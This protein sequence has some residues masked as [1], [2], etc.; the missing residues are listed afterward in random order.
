M[1]VAFYPVDMLHRFV[2][3]FKLYES[4]CIRQTCVVSTSTHKN[5]KVLQASHMLESLLDEVA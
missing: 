5:A 3:C 2:A 4:I 1:A